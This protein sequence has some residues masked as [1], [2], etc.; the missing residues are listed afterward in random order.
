MKAQIKRAAI[1]TVGWFFIITGVIGLFLPVMQG[2]LFIFIGL[3][4]LS[5]EYV[6]AHNLLQKLRA[7]F[8]RVAH[9]VDRAEHKAMEWFHRIGHRRKRHTHAPPR[10]AAADGKD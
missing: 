4:I 9:M 7:R 1:I 6:W 5:S 8:P 2:M 3:L 10:P